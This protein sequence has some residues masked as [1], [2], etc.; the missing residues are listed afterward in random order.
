MH[1]FS[2]R[3]VGT[4]VS[5]LIATAWSTPAPGAPLPPPEVHM[6]A[7]CSGAPFEASSGI[8]AE[9][10][11]SIVSTVG[12]GGAMGSAVGGPTPQIGLKANAFW[13]SG[14]FSVGA[15]IAADLSYR[16]MV[17]AAVAG[18]PVGTPVPVPIL[19]SVAG[20][21]T[22]TSDLGHATAEVIIR[23]PSSTPHSFVSSDGAVSPP[24]GG[25]DSFNAT[26]SF[27]VDV[28]TMLTVQMQA[29]C[30]AA[31]NGTSLARQNESCF[32][33]VDPLFAFDQAAFDTYAADAGFETFTLADYY[34][35]EFSPG[36]MNLASATVPE[37]PAVVALGLSLGAAARARRR[38]RLRSA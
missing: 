20:T 4:A 2:T 36:I 22:K 16:M 38:R 14:P 3:R 25:T 13:L 19:F 6:G 31:A 29:S 26:H 11:C 18:N 33:L 15:N 37:P 8:G 5:I 12:G 7:N 34:R 35:F 27:S 9:V 17:T 30:I 10:N 1:G 24:G 23:Y 32:A 28:G 21:A